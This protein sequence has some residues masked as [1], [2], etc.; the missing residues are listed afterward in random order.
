MMKDILD[1]DMISE[2]KLHAESIDDMEDHKPK[3]K[4]RDNEKIREDHDGKYID[5]YSEKYGETKHEIIDAMDTSTRS[6][7]KIKFDDEQAYG[8]KRSYRKL[9]NYDDYNYKKRSHK[10]YDD[11]EFLSRRHLTEEQWR[12]KES[13]E[14]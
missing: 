4:A 11:D 13:K 12:L 1:G 14:K 6:S 3:K 5:D 9:N 2:K 10:D 7:K 8:N